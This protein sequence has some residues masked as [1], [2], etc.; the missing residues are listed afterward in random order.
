MFRAQH[1]QYDSHAASLF[2]QTNLYI[3]DHLTAAQN[4]TFFLLKVPSIWKWAPPH[5][6]ENTLFVSCPSG[7]MQPLFFIVMS[8]LMHH[9]NSVWK[10]LDPSAEFAKPN[11]IKFLVQLIPFSIYSGL[12]ALP[13][14]GLLCSSGYE[15]L[16]WEAFFPSML[17]PPL[18]TASWVFVLF[19]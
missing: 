16:Q 3:C 14:W 11:T 1:V 2:F 15:H 10:Y 17:S 18:Q 19:V 13:L 5:V 6:V 12:T 8:K 4:W 7:K 9:I